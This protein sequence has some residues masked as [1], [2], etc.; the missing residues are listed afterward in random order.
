MPDVVSCSTV[1][2]RTQRDEV[3]RKL[4][5]A[6]ET[7]ADPAERERLLAE[8]V[9]LNLPLAREVAARFSG[10]G[11]A[12]DD[13]EQIAAL[14]LLKALH[15]FRADDGRSFLAFAVPTVS[16]E[17]KRYFR[18]AA[19]LVRIPR[20]LH[21]VLVELERIETAPESA[22][23]RLDHSRWEVDEALRA[24]AC[25]YGVPAEAV[26][27]L[28]ADTDALSVAIERFE[29]ADLARSVLAGL[30]ARSRKILV[31]RF[32][33]ELSQA[34]IGAAVGLSQVQVSR[35]IRRALATARA[36]LAELGG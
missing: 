11:I 19:W 30:D 7:S 10:R 8:A 33:K 26:T 21:E 32:V 15:A 18:D 20:R 28:P 29:Q 13:L 27:D 31:L 24:R 17:L 3:T 22:E 9:L 34:E 14:G 16:G 23:G 25:R 5:Q 12:D 35:E 4:L 2:D 36:R 6:R 1:E